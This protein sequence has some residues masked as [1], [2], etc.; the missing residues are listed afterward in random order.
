MENLNAR[1]QGGIRFGICLLELYTNDGHLS[2]RLLERDVGPETR[3]YARVMKYPVWRKTTCRDEDLDFMV[4][5]EEPTRH[6]ADYFT[7]RA[8]KR[9][10]T[11]HD[12]RVGRELGPPTV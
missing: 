6:D 5:K 11:A 7:V 2:T 10:G 1:I 4:R 12:V 3:D 9:N 8:V